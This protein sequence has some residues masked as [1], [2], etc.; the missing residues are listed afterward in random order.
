MNY[1][2]ND[3]ILTGTI[4]NSYP[5]TARLRIDLE[6]GQISGVYWYDKVKSELHVSGLGRMN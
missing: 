6:E 5:I 2:L 3:K 1:P 4:N